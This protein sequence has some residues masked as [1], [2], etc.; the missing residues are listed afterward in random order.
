MKKIGILGATGSIGTQ[1]IE[2]IRKFKNLYTIEFLVSYSNYE[3]LFKLAEEFNIY[4]V[5][6]ID[7]SVNVKSRKFKVY[8]GYE[9]LELIENIDLLLVSTTGTFSIF[10]TLRAIENNINIALANKEILVSFG[11]IVKERLKNS[12]STI[13]PVDSEHSAIFQLINP[14]KNEVERIILTA[15]GGPFLNFNIE[16]MEKVNVE[17]ALNHPTWKMGKKITI[18]SATLFNKAL[19]IIEAYYL[20]NTKNIDVVVHPQSIVHSFVQLKDGSLLAQLSFPD[21]KIPIAYALSYPERL[22]NPSTISHPYDFSNLTFIKP[23]FEKFPSL[24]I[25]YFCLEKLSYYPTIMNASNEVAVYSFLEGKI[26]FRDIFYI[27]EK[28]IEVLEKE[29]LSDETLEDLLYVDRISR[30]ISNSLV[31][32]KERI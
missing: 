17:M 3:K 2:I 4:K 5:G 11:K 25:A 20:F 18:D 21:M 24:K 1:A 7:E 16:E 10:P 22:E 15:S 14:Y 26:K 12:K 19:E 9:I 23:D 28:T 27:V 29:K 8:K 13:I 30:D 6:I 32:G 31:S